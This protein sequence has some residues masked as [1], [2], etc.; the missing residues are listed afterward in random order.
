MST[1]VHDRLTEAAVGAVDDCRCEVEELY[2]L[3]TSSWQRL[4]PLVMA[5]VLLRL[6]RSRA[7]L[8]RLAGEVRDAARESDHE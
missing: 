5:R 2:Q 6:E 7:A 4:P 1:S 3:L 8:S